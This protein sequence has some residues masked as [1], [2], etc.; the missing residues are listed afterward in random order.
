VHNP[1]VTFVVLN[2]NQK[3]DTLALLDSLSKCKYRRTSTIVL[4]NQSTDGSCTAIHELHPDATIVRLSENLGYAGN[5]NVGITTALSLG[6][7]WVFVLNEDTLVAPDCVAE[8]MRVAR[9]DENIGVIGPLVCHFTS[10]ELVQ[11]AGGSLG[12]NWS[13]THLAQNTAVAGLSLH[14]REV[15]WISGCAI[16]MRRET[17]EHVGALDERFFY[18]WEETEWCLR[19]KRA[20]WRILQVPAA[21]IWHK[22]VQVDYSPSPSVSYY[23]TRN[24]LLL[25][26]KHCAP[27][28]VKVRTWLELIRTLASFSIK[29]RWRGMRAHRDAIFWGINDFLRGRWGKMPVRGSM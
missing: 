15:D 21:R 13:S 25:Q 8:M 16:M 3:R 26:Q 22:G 28:P 18:Y 14:P 23:D 1:L 27:L 12:G 10:P 6:A 7:D 11:S 2:T 20:G 24:R 4:D 5:N 29:P 17:I 19:A 9:S